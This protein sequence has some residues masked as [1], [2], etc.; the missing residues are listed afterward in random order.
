VAAS[1][2]FGIG[3]VNKLSTGDRIAIKNNPRR[4]VL[5]SYPLFSIGQSTAGELLKKVL[6]IFA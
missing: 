4:A 5:K 1:I 2:G 3:S 6:H